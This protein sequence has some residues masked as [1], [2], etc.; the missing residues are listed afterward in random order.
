MRRAFSGSTVIEVAH[1]IEYFMDLD[2]VVVMDAGIVQ[3]VGDP[4]TLIRRNDLSS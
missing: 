2:R 4:R 3:A 1:Q